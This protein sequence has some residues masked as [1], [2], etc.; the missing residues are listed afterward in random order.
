M[1]IKILH[2]VKGA[3]QA[4]G[5]TV[6]IDV[7]RAFTTACFVMRNGVERIIP[8][9][10]VDQAYRLKEKNPGFILMGE[11]KGKKLPGFDHGNSPA[12]IENADFEGKTVIQTTSAGTKGIV[13][14]KNADEI[15]TGSFVNSAAVAGYIRRVK[16]EAVS[17]VCMGNEGKYIADEDLF[18][19]EYIKSI[20]EGTFYDKKAAVEILRKGRGSIFFD[21]SNN[22]WGPQRDFYLCTTFDLFSFVL[23]AEKSP[24]ADEG[25]PLIQL[26][27][28]VVYLEAR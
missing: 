10:G 9:G 21:Q 8:V 16:P 27:K 22:D 7:F 19:A 24:E 2:L 25:R 18:C 14:A 13:N 17:L 4:K 1:D 23:R 12:Q 3:E 11:R 28:D 15:I 5:L 26:V 20:I 6:I